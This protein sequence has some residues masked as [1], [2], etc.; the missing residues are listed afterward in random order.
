MLT[1]LPFGARR[2]G[3]Q[4]L[5]KPFG[6]I[7]AARFMAGAGHELGEGFDL[8]GFV[9]WLI[10]PGEIARAGLLGTQPRAAPSP[11]RSGRATCQ[12]TSRNPHKLTFPAKFATIS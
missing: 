9:P 12:T 6:E 2:T 8:D 5:F 7:N 10:G 3:G 1:V 11:H 4:A